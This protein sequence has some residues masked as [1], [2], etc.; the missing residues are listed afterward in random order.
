[1]DDSS[2]GGARMPLQS[3]HGLIKPIGHRYEYY[4]TELC[5]RGIIPGLELRQ[6]FVWTLLASAAPYHF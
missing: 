2:E 6:V 5:R 3:V 4:I 1:M